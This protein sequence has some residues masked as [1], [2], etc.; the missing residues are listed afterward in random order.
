MGKIFSETEI[1]A[2]TNHIHLYLQELATIEERINLYS[3]RT[4]LD[5][6]R[7]ELAELPESPA[8]ADKLLTLQMAD[9]VYRLLETGDIL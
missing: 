4:Y 2:L 7:E 6:V 9:K 5:S 3:F 8:N 1:S